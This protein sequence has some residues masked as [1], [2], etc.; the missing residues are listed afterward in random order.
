MS[1]LVRENSSMYQGRIEEF[2]KGVAGLG[3]RCKLP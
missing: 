1:S 2:A 3:E